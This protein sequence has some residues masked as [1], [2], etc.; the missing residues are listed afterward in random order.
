[1]TVGGVRTESGDVDQSFTVTGGGDNSNRCVNASG[2]VNT[3]NLQTAS[4]SIQ[5]ASDTEDFEQD[6]I[7]SELTVDGSSTVSCA[8][9]VNQA[10]AAS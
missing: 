2:V 5:Y 4:G 7:G 9:Q 10:A 6:D 8:Q 3:G 1:M